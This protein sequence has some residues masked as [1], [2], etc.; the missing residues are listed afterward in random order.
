MEKVLLN[1]TE[2]YFKNN[3]IFN[4]GSWLKSSLTSLISFYNEVT[5]QADKGKLVHAVFLDFSE[6]FG[7]LS[8]HPSGQLFQM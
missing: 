7:S 3:A 5:S 6:A 1:S 8:Q 4:M 2:K